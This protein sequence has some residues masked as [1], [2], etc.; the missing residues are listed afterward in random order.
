[1]Q[2]ASGSEARRARASEEEGAQQP[3]VRQAR[4]GDTTVNLII[5]HTTK[6]I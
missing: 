6:S 4:L 3:A 1:M 5:Q 2:S